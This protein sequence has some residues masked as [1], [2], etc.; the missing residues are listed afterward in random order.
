MYGYP[1]V[2]TRF[3]PEVPIMFG[4]GGYSH[5][6]DNPALLRS[7]NVK[8]ILVKGAWMVEMCRPYWGDLV[9]EWAAPINTHVWAP[10]ASARKDID[11]IVY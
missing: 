11:L 4:A 1:H 7:Q 3:L 8:R 10:T 9:H 6:L 2:L 5:P